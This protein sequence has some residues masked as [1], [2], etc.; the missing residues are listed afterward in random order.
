MKR[1][2]RRLCAFI[3]KAFTYVVCCSTPRAIVDAVNEA[4]TVE[5]FDRALYSAA[6]FE[7]RSE[8]CGQAYHL[9]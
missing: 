4:A 2:L 8:P 3:K 7:E 6:G 1:M 5:E 9:S